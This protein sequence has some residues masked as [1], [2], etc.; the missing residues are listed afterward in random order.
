MPF[1]HHLDGRH[2]KRL[3][4]AIVV[5]LASLNSLHR[6]GD[7]KTYTDNVSAHGA[8]VVSSHAW[9]PGEEAQVTPLK[10][11]QP[12][13][14][15]VIYCRQFAIGHY[16]VGLNF[17]ERPIHWSTS[18]ILGSRNFPPARPGRRRSDCPTRHC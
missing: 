12:A 18:L 16:F 1:D 9:Q 7:E 2:E 14:G 6:D 11:G 4:I 17:P 3:P 5:R 10:Y 13:H 15:K 8:R